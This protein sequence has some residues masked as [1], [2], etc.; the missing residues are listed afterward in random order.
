MK[1][2]QELKIT[3]DQTKERTEVTVMAPDDGVYILTYRNPVTMEYIQ[4]AKI[5]CWASPAEMAAA[6]RPYYV[7]TV[8]SGVSVTKV[9]LDVN[10]NP[11][12]STL[13]SDIKGYRYVIEVDKL[14]EGVTTQQILVAK[15]GTLA[16]ITVK[17]PL[18]VQTSSPP[19][20]GAFIVT[21]K[22][23][24]GQASATHEIPAQQSAKWA[25]FTIS[26]QCQGLYNKIEG[27][28]CDY[29]DQVPYAANGLC[30]RIRFTGINADPGQFTIKSGTT[31]PLTGKD[32]AVAWRT[33]LPYG[34]NLFYAPVPFEFLKTYEEK[35]QV[36]VSVDGEPAVCHNMTC[37]FTYVEAAGEVTTATFD[38][39]TK[40]LVIT[41][42]ALPTLTPPPARRRLQPE[43]AP[44][45]PSHRR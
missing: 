2:I 38:P 29:A 30:V 3:L 13:P 15:V 8:G 7:D 35:P 10:R 1:E 45:L 44:V 36:V 17:L 5:T 22:D 18:E 41:G 4:S 37:D 27:L 25:A 19:L 6:V 14:I 24:D 23:K 28:E 43:V 12:L 26:Q 31:A 21:C 34:T 9:N 20:G 11:T 16:Q 33:P 39:A 32:V 42:T 40:K